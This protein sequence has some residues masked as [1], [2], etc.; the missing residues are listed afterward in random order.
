MD[1]DR[2]NIEEYLTTD[3]IH[4]PHEKLLLLDLLNISPTLT[5]AAGAIMD[6]SSYFSYFSDLCLFLFMARNSSFT[7]SLYCFCVGFFYVLFQVKS[8][9]ALELE[10]VL[11]SI[12]VFWRGG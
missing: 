10:C 5:E 11:V 3:S 6:I 4:K 7:P 12:V 1:L 9:R 8:P 2:R